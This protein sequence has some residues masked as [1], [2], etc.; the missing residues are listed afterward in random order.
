MQ[1]SD[2]IPETEAC[3]ATGVSARTLQRFAEAGY[4]QLEKDLDGLC[5]FSK[6][7]LDALFGLKN[8]EEQA[9][10]PEEPA[11]EAPEENYQP[12]SALIER[13]E[14][15]STDT[16]PPA[17]AVNNPLQNFSAEIE[18]LRNLTK[19]QEKLLDA[20]DDELS[21]L[22]QQRDWLKQR[23]EKL[24]QKAERDQLLLLSE[25]QTV[26]SLVALQAS[27]KSPFRAALEYF[28]FV[29]ETQ[30]LNTQ[31]EISRGEASVTE[32]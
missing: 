7:E 5:R 30:S 28:G 14:V 29:Q 13:L 15:V 2:F 32:K 23:I 16:Q 24:E 6:Q 9:A 19:I 25:A 4:L 3:D 17:A 31:K 10:H 26:K 20:R 27:K 18:T 1:N 11:L 22:K 21:D 12:P 8:E